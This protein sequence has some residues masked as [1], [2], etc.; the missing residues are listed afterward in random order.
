MLAQLRAS[1]S[2]RRTAALVQAEV[3]SGLGGVG[4]TQTAL[5]YA[6]RYRAEYRDV[7]WVDAETGLELRSSFRRIAHELGLPELNEDE[8]DGTIRLVR[9]WLETNCG[10]LLILDNA[11]D[12]DSLRPFLPRGTTGHVLITS[13]VSVFDALGVASPV[14]ISP[15]EPAEA[16]ELLLSRTGRHDVDREEREA[17][18]KLVEE[19]G[20]LPLAIEQAAAYLVPIRAKFAEYLAGFR[21]RQIAL[22]EKSRPKLGGYEQTVATTWELNF[23]EVQQQSPAAAEL[24]LFSA[25]LSPA[26]IPFRLLTRAAPELGPT[27]SAALGG[28]EK[29]PLIVKELLAR[30]SGYSL[31]AIDIAGESYT[32]HRLVQQVV[33]QALSE[34]EARTWATR[35]IAALGEICLEI[36]NEGSNLFKANLSALT[37]TQRSWAPH[38]SDV[39]TRYSSLAQYQTTEMAKLMCAICVY[40]HGIGQSDS[41][42]QQL[43]SAIRIQEAYYPDGHPDLWSSVDA[44]ADA[45]VAQ[46]RLVEA[47]KLILRA[48]A[49]R[50]NLLGTEHPDTLES[51]DS[52]SRWYAMQRRFD[53]ALEIAEQTLRIRD[54]FGGERK[55]DILNSMMSI[56]LI[57]SG[58]KQYDHAWELAEKM[59]S[60]A[61]S[62]CQK[63]HPINALP[64]ALMGMIRYAQG[65]TRE[66]RE[67]FEHALWLYERTFGANHPLPIDI[68]YRLAQVDARQGHLAE[69]NKSLGRI[70][71]SYE[72]IL[73]EDDPRV[74]E[75]LRQHA[76]VMRRLRRD[77]S[78]AKMDA[79]ADEIERKN[80]IV[81]G[82]PAESRLSKWKTYGSSF[83]L[84]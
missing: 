31:I 12:A 62:I 11:T 51:M 17:A 52:L 1:L 5:E 29:D 54:K 19:L 74:A 60:M 79:R 82:N 4:K 6:Y 10:W 56:A 65:K 18:I 70:R 75:V 32:M 48:L 35:S 68:A 49:G 34:S 16:L 2:A 72:T 61:Q 33:R 30:L 26:P 14:R 15:M 8:A 37:A 22:L 24:L 77:A 45:L 84:R 41:T 9:H 7:F 63:D 69:A 23:R 28:A 43:R 44:L 71:K 20:Y 66:A 76:Q 46:G 53:D 27:L 58:R 13:R 64:F 55:L 47:H 50:E 78:A 36:E 59:I 38:A 42:E 3:L 73:G 39:V 40:Q 25:F 81:H 83:R 67:L 21:T 80:G 57:Y